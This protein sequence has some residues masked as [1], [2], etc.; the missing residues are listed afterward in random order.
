MN[1]EKIAAELQIEFT[2]LK[3][4]ENP[5]FENQYVNRICMAMKQ[6]HFAPELYKIAAECKDFLDF[7]EYLVSICFVE[8]YFK[9]NFPSEV[10]AGI[11]HNFY[12]VVL[13]EFKKYCDRL[14]EIKP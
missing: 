6:Q 2:E 12:D 8:D 5:H 9:K 14:Q 3:G 1:F 10:Y 11:L 13:A 7:H 4:R